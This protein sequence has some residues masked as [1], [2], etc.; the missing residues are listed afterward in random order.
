MGYRS[1]VRILL[2]EKDF[3]EL[4]EKTQEFCKTNSGMS[5]DPD[6]YNV[7]KHLDIRQERTGSD[8]DGNEV[9]YVYFGWDYIKWYDCDGLVSFIER[10][11]LELEDYHFVRIGENWDDLDEYHKLDKTDVDCIG[12]I[13]CFDETLEKTK[14]EN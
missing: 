11:I 10:E 8:E 6:G 14:G 13:R 12:V 9:K 2:P 7:F 1:E 4:V 3:N 5:Y